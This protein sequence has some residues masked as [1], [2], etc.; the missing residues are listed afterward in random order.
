MT[1]MYVDKCM[2]LEW[3]AQK[4]K[5]KVWKKKEFKPKLLPVSDSESRHDW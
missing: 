3:F 4:N 1:Y 2:Q 5:Q